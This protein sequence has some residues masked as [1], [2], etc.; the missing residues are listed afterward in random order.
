[1]SS[2]ISTDQAVAQRV[3]GLPC[4][5]NPSLS[6]V[7]PGLPSREAQETLPM[8]GENTSSERAQ[9]VP[10]GSSQNRLF[11]HVADKYLR[12]PSPVQPA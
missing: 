2:S 5:E 6:S 4:G 3:C 10:S 8:T 7:A 1:M 9:Q 12:S 11:L